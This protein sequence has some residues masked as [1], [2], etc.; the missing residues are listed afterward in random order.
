M[1]V[2]SGVE[3]ERGGASRA[4]VLG[5][6]VAIAGCSLIVSALALHFQ[7]PH[8]LAQQSLGR[9]GATSDAL[10]LF[11]ASL[12]IGLIVFTS[13]RWKDT[14]R[15]SAQAAA[16]RALYDPLTGLP[17]RILLHERLT[18]ALAK[19]RQHEARVAVLF[20]DLDRFKAVNDEY[21]HDEGD[22]VL[23]AIA[24]RLQHSLR[25]D[26]SVARFGGD[27]FVVYLH[28]VTEMEVARSIA[29]KIRHAV[30]K[31]IEGRDGQQYTVDAS[32]GVSLYPDDGLDV[33]TLLR[34]ADSR[35]FDQK[36]LHR[37]L[38]V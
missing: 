27:E 23:I 1:G 30:N 26:D 31:P 21:G 17:N 6:L 8:R 12:A 34:V 28:G 2:G 11:L 7:I 22:K 4:R 37:I 20:I 9:N 25:H 33:E 5:D 35:M 14:V 16:H 19:A 36:R 32:V 38:S 29:D 24:D 3:K 10:V 13:R 18:E 15:E